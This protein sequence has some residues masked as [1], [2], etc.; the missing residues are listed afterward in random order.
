M[1]GWENAYSITIDCHK[2]LNVPYES[3]I[4]LVKEQ[5]KI[6]QTGNIPKF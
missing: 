5:Y 6:L 4:F 3:A 2:W 1:E